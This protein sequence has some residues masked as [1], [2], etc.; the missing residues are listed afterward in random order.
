[1][2][3]NKD[4]IILYWKKDASGRYFLSP[5][6]KTGRLDGPE[7]EVV[8]KMSEE[9]TENQM[10]RATQTTR[11]IRQ[12]GPKRWYP[13]TEEAAGTDRRPVCSAFFNKKPE[14]MVRTANI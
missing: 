9:E 12:P 2:T 10:T 7:L 8:I 4:R 1:M 5:G 13:K 3:D 6:G 14:L 11:T